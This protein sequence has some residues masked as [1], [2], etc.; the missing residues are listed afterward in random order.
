MKTIHIATVLYYAID[1]KTHFELVYTPL[2]MPL[3]VIGFPT[4]I[5]LEFSMAVHIYQLIIHGTDLL[6]LLAR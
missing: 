2:K 6:T 3:M 5:I 4:T 1:C